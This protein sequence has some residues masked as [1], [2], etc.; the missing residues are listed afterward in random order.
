MPGTFAPTRYKLRYWLFIAYAVGVPVFIKFDHTGETHNFSLFNAQSIASITLTL[1]CA[2]LL[3]WVTLISR[4]NIQA[5]PVAFQRLPLVA[6]LVLLVVASAANPRDNFAISI[7]RLG[8]WILAFL[9]L[10]GIYSR[11]PFENALD[12]ASQMVAAICWISVAIVWLALPVVPSLAFSVP[13]EVTGAIQFRLGGYLI[14][15][16]TFGVIVGIVFWHALLFQR[17]A[18]RMVLCSFALLSL[19]LTYSRGAWVGFVLSA[20]VY[21]LVSRRT[22]AR[23]IVGAGLATAALLSIL[24]SG[25]VTHLLER[26]AGENNLTTLSGRAMVWAAALKGIEQKP[27]LGYGYIDG[28]KHMIP[29]YMAVNYWVPSHCHNDL[30]QAIASGGIFAGCLLVWV[31]MRGIVQGF[32]V[33]RSGKNELFL[34]LAFVQLLVFAIVTPLFMV[35]FRQLGAILL[36]CVIAFSERWKTLR[37]EM[38]APKQEYILVNQ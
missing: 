26:G 23:L 36:V 29:Q 1:G 10:L 31:Y 38:R 30:L 8:E 22:S 17:S 14:H 3:F 37:G 9:L 19:A 11:E 34:F 35:Q 33:C 16:N 25:S 18:K 13:E 5:R 24:F 21:V 2:T 28:V 15:P 27:F 32:R 7:Y 12:L 6:L 4:R 20:I